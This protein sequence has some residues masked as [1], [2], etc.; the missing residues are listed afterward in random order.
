MLERQKL[1]KVSKILCPCESY[2][3]VYFVGWEGS[4]RW[5]QKDHRGT[6]LY[7]ALNSHCED[8]GLNTKFR[9]HYLVVRFAMS[10]DTDL[11]FSPTTITTKT[12]IS[13]VYWV[14]FK[15]QV[16]SSQKLMKKGQLY[17][18]FVGGGSQ[19]NNLSRSSARKWQSWTWTHLPGVQA[20]ILIH[21]LRLPST[22]VW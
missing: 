6:S 16:Q 8:F 14:L 2:T 7:T 5:G 15:D 9:S 19:L 11:E 20:S 13:N 18:S 1:T 12:A 22:R 21:E 10:I 17:I 4:C 3:W